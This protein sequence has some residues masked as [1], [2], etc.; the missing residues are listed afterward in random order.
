M[1]TPDQGPGGADLHLELPAEGARR[2]ALAQAL[3]SAVRSGRLAGGTR[4]P[5]YRTLAADLGLARNAVADAYAELVAEGWFTA[6][7]GSGTQVAEGVATADTPAAPAG[8]APDRPRHDLLQG[9]PD[10]ASFPRAAWAASARRALAEAPT[11]A[12]GPGDPQGRPELRRA[13]AGYLSRARGVRCGP[14]NIVIC[15]GFA[16]GLRLLSSVRPRDWAVEAYGLPFHHG[17]LQAA[18]VHPH[19]VPVDEDGARLGEELPSRARTLLLTPAHQFPTGGRLL[20]ARR[21]AAVEWARGTDGV[22]VEDDYDGEFRYDRKPVGALQGLAPE[23]VV[24]AGSLSKSLSPALRLGWL[25]LPD[26]LRDQVL[27]AKGL[28][29]SWAS[30]LDQLAL[31]DFIECGAYD[32]HVR[33]MRLRYR[34][35]RDQLAAVLAARAPEVRVTGISAGLHAVL[36]LP[37]GRESPALAAAHAAGLALDGLSSYQHPADPAPPREGLVVGYATPPDSAF[38]RALGVLA[39]VVGAAGAEAEAFG[40]C[41]IRI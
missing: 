1:T 4:L 30:T 21:A 35:R 31:A 16:N 24:Y 22:I 40:S 12:F 7:Q 23:H 10:P 34:N 6:R 11:E 36:E 18:G 20:P 25:V 2:T 26:Q 17:I 33:R 27:A 15:S 41:S 3:R 38:T 39:G 5:P 13:L 37:P 8:P 28:R 19:P 9:K 29:E 32:R 14:E